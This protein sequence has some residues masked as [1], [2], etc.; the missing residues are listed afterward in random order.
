MKHV[1]AKCSDCSSAFMM[2]DDSA[3]FCERGGYPKRCRP[4][5]Q[6]RA[7]RRHEDAAANLRSKI[8]KLRAARDNAVVRSRRAQARAEGGAA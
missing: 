5:M 6:L 3:S 4:C 8:G 7:A 2:H 1:E